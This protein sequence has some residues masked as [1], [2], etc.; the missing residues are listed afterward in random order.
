[1]EEL[2]KNKLT[3]D[4]ISVVSKFLHEND[5][6]IVKMAVDKNY[7]PKMKYPNIDIK[8]NFNVFMNYVDWFVAS[9]DN[10]EYLLCDL[11]DIIGD[12][13][14]NIELR[15][16]A[17]KYIL[18]KNVVPFHSCYL[19][20]EK[21]ISELIVQHYK[22]EYILENF[23]NTMFKYLTYGCEIDVDII[24]YLYSIGLRLDKADIAYIIF[25]EKRPL[26]EW[27]ITH[28]FNLSYN[29]FYEVLSRSMDDDKKAEVI[30]WLLDHGCPY[31]P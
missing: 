31:K 6:E 18:N 25:D 8:K 16:R 11:E 1:M 21:E 2:L 12:K 24:D 30:A 4:C 7:K 10:V 9:R 28:G 13:C 20:N 15:I 23:P 14:I 29:V 22:K 17:A 26:W 3:R 19:F 5:I 27:A